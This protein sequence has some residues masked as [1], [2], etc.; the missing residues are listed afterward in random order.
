MFFLKVLRI[1]LSK[2]DIQTKLFHRQKCHEDD[3][4]CDK[5]F[6]IFRLMMF[7]VYIV[8]NARTILMYE[9]HS[10]CTVYPIFFICCKLCENEEN[11]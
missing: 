11:L 3:L 10:P 8:S 7:T 1:V 5:S 9:T 6:I 2:T 4:F